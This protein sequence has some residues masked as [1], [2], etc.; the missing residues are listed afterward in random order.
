[1]YEPIINVFAVL[2]SVS[3]IVYFIFLISAYLDVWWLVDSALIVA[4]NKHI[5]LSY[6]FLISTML[7][8][9]LGLFL[10]P[11]YGMVGI[12]LGAVLIDLILIPY[13][14]KHRKEILYSGTN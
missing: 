12:A 5:G 6:K 4:A 11:E 8:C 13:C 2:N 1:M 14:L 9:L 10:L 3:F 7:S